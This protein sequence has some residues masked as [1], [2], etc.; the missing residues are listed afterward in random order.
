MVDPLERNDP[1]GSSSQ[2]SGKTVLHDRAR[3]WVADE[4]PFVVIEVPVDAIIW[5][6]Q[7]EW[8]NPLWL[9]SSSLNGNLDDLS[10]LK[11]ADLE[12]LILVACA[13]VPATTWG[14]FDLIIQVALRWLPVDITPWG[15]SYRKAHLNSCYISHWILVDRG[16]IVG[17]V[18]GL[19]SSQGRHKSQGKQA[20]QFH[21]YFFLLLII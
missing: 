4:N 9:I 16:F 5:V 17:V 6:L 13:G 21:H 7:E 12:V 20:R 1:H 2:R 18:V 14:T 3:V 11:E 8:C 19:S 15:S 10:G